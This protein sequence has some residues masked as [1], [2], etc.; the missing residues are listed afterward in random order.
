MIGLPRIVELAQLLVARTLSE[1]D[2]A[3]DATVGKGH[4]TLWLAQQV[5]STGRVLGLDLQMVALTTTRR[6]L[7]E[8]NLSNRVIL[9]Q[10]RHEDLK[11]LLSARDPLARPKVMMFNLGYLPGGDHSIATRPES[12]LCALEAAV[13]QVIPGGLVSV[14]VY[15]GHPL[16]REESRQILDWASSSRTPPM[17]LLRCDLPWTH[18]PS[19]WLLALSPE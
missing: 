3:I 19:P 7:I 15:P 14:V 4:D 10:A 8:A 9:A 17:K 12:T 13:T 1:G 18:Q 5:G 2:F 11:T 16:G 6:R